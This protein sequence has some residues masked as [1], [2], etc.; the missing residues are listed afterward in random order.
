[1]DGSAESGQV[2]FATLH[3]KI[4]YGGKHLHT[5]LRG[6]LSDGQ[7]FHFKY[8]TRRKERIVFYHQQPQCLPLK[9]V[10]VRKLQQMS[11]TL[12]MGVGRI[13]FQRWQ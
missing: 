10:Q 5:T 11:V 1:M 2:A 9:D 12:V 8:I 4:R 3:P 13:F 6:E 7:L